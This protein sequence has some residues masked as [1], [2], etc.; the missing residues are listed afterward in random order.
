MTHDSA[1]RAYVDR[2]RA[3]GRTTK[4]IRRS[5]KRYLARQIYRLLDTA[6]P[7]PSPA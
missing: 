4:E 7:V 6:D 3:E 5:L 1:T 2:R